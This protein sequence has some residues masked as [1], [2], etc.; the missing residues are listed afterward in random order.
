VID[1]HRNISASAVKPYLLA[2]VFDDVTAGIG[3]KMGAFG[4]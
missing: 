2:Q 1:E 3:S 4:I